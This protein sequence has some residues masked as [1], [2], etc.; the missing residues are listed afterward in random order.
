MVIQWLDNRKF[1]TKTW[2]TKAHNRKLITD[3]KYDKFRKEI[4]NISVKLNNYIKSIGKI[5]G[6]QVKED[7]TDFLN[8]LGSTTE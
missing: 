2:L 8:Y 5:A 1:E 7:D 6:N 4:R 3:I